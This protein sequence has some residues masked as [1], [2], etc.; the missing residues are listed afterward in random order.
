MKRQMRLTKKLIDAL[1]ACPADAKTREIEYSDVDVAGLRLVVNRLGR[2]SWLLRYTH[3][4]AKRA[5]KLGD[6]P[7]V[8]IAQARQLAIDARSLLAKG[9]DPQVRAAEQVQ[10]AMTLTQFM[11]H[12][13]LP[14]AKGAQRSYRDTLGRWKHH[15][16]P[17]FGH[18][19]LTALKT[20]DIQRF[21]DQKRIELSPATANRIL[22]LLKAALTRALLW[23][24]G[25]LERNPV[26]GVR[27]H[28]EN[29]H[30]ERYLAGPEL[31]R[32]LDALD[33]E[34]SRTAAAVIKFLLATGVR[35]T[36][37]L[38]AKFSDMD[39]QQATWRLT[40][41]KNGHARTVYLNPI[42]L[43]RLCC[44]TP[45]KPSFP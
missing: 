19:A 28:T 34:P 17:V 21:H 10:A 13:Y 25:G 27:M 44:T 41:T 45:P 38:T 24:L 39:L 42:A 12:D 7:G 4:A 26:Q 15:L 8:D 31:K 18:L 23:Q 33:Q 6:Y 2:K 1:P 37:A 14:Y 35:R 3:E 29:N 20:Q 36:E 32:F 43:E 40:K 9:T 16:K 30:R 5:M 22:A 11:E